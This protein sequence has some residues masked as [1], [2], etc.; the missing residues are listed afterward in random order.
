MLS[1]GLPCLSFGFKAGTFGEK[2]SEKVDFC[3]CLNVLCTSGN[4]I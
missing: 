1:C 2:Y 4:D 3:G